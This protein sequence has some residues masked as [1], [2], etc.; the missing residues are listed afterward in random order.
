PPGH[1]DMRTLLAVPIGGSSPFKGNLYLTEKGDGRP[2]TADDEASLV[3]FATAAAL[4][5]DNAHASRGRR[6]VAVAEERL[7]IAREMHDGLAQVLAYVNTKAQAVNEFLAL[8]DVDEARRQLDQL[9]AAAR[10]V[11]TD[12]RE[13][14]LSL[15]S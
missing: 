13:G 3:R 8:G 2:F 7:R 5:I 10:E 11:A 14:I 15:R 6:L 1:P 4:A 12:A 9:A